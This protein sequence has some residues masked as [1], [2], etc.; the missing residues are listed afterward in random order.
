[1]LDVLHRNRTGATLDSL[2]LGTY[3][4]GMNQDHSEILRALVNGTV[5]PEEASV[6]LAPGC[7]LE[8]TTESRTVW[9]AGQAI[10]VEKR[11]CH[12]IAGCTDPSQNGGR[13]CGDWS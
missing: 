4:D 9:G 1:V 12:E 5:A 10:K 11:T 7:H 2:I 6:R 13:I 3:A 8:T